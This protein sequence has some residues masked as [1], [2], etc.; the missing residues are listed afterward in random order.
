MNLFFFFSLQWHKRND[1]SEQTYYSQ[2]HQ[3][4][5][6][7]SGHS[8][9]MPCCTDDLRLESPKRS[10]C[11]PLFGLSRST[12]RYQDHRRLLWNRPLLSTKNFSF[13]RLGTRHVERKTVIANSDKTLDK[14]LELVACRIKP[15]KTKG[16]CQTLHFDFSQNESQDEEAEDEEGNKSSETL[17]E[18]MPDLTQQE[19]STF[20]RS[21][22]TFMP[23]PQIAE[24]QFNTNSLE[25]ETKLL[26][27]L[28]PITCSTPQYRTSPLARRSSGK[29]ITMMPSSYETKP[30][31]S[32]LYSTPSC[33]YQ[34]NTSI[35]SSKYTSQVEP[36]YAT[37]QK[38]R[39]SA[40]S[41]VSSLQS[42]A[43]Q[44]GSNSSMTSFTSPLVQRKSQPNLT[45]STLSYSTTA[46]TSMS[47]PGNKT[48]ESIYK[49][50]PPT[51]TM[52]SVTT[53]C[54]VTTAQDTETKYA[55]VTSLMTSKNPVTSNNTMP[56]RTQFNRLASQVASKKISKGILKNQ[57][58]G[59]Q[60]SIETQSSTTHFPVYESIDDLKYIDDTSS[61]SSFL[62][63]QK[64]N[65]HD[66]GRRSKLANPTQNNNNTHNN[67]NAVSLVL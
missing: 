45:S 55:D 27:D 21:R 14:D 64:I 60:C 63:E 52:Y 66:S 31:L 4:P 6:D 44:F 10:S 38:P 62:M 18:D 50:N 35:Y 26:S 41:P 16:K 7:V 49:S 42:S 43:T 58:S 3:T 28:S 24:T 67:K 65:R 22:S 5:H 1:N 39:T 29:T 47:T 40:V 33:I 56:I 57:K 25:S 15:P 48:Y 61:E 59:S 23:I 2:I 34:T 46:T 12:D 37:V 53:T 20:R 9:A 11:L 19:S 30:P 51:L 17:L 54:E 36:Y 8:C 32:S 13:P